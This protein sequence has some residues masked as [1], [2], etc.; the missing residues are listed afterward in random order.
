MPDQSAEP[1]ELSA[2]KIEDAHPF[3]DAAQQAG[4]RSYLHYFPLLY[5]YGQDKAHTLLWERHAG[6]ILVYLLRRRSSGTRINL[7]LPPFPF[8]PVAL[9]HALQRMRELRGDRSGRIIWVQQEEALLVAREGLE[10]YFKEDELILDRAAV[11]A[12]E[13]PGF[14]SLRQELSRAR[15]P[16]QVETRPYTTD[17]QPACL[18]LVEQWKDRAHSLSMR[19]DGYRHTVSCLARAEHFPRSLLHGLVVEV[20]G[21]VQGFAFSGPITQTHG[22]NFLRISNPKYRGLPHLLGYRIMAEF[23]ELIYFND[24]TSGRDGLREL[25]QPFRPVEMHGLFGARDK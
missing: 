10:I 17:D 1:R 13:G 14:R 5:Y 3:M 18:A 23:P 21:E 20:K 2:I 24:S 6:S 11:M 16:G 4:A 9:R 25:S 8:E 22:C 12:V 15:K 19:V 7:Y